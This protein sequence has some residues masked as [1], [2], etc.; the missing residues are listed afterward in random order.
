MKMKDDMVIK[1]I[2]QTR[3]TFCREFRFDVKKIAA[4]LKEREQ[5]HPD[6]IRTPRQFSVKKVAV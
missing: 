4:E 1:K 2:R 5:T 6:S 3:K